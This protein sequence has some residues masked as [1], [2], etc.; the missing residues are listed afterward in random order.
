M[1]EK[2]YLLDV[3]VGYTR[4]LKEKLDR[5]LTKVEIKKAMQMYISGISAEKALEGMKNETI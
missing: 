5:E 4:Y 3:W 2:E 1:K